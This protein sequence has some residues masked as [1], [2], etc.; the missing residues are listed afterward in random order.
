MV[1]FS[2]RPVP[3]PAGHTVLISSDPSTDDDLAPHAAVW[4]ESK[5]GTPWW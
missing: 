4:L 2:A 5:G 3:L 1:N